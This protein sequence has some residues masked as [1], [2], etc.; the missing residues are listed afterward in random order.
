MGRTLLHF[1]RLIAVSILGL[2]LLIFGIVWLIEGISDHKPL[3][4]L[5]G[6]LALAIVVSAFFYSLSR[7]RQQAA[8]ENTTSGELLRKG[9]RKCWRCNTEFEIASA[10]KSP[11]PWYVT[12]IGVILSLVPISSGALGFWAF[13]LASFNAVKS[14][15]CLV[16]GI[17]FLLYVMKSAGDRRVRCPACGRWCGTTRPTPS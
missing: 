17:A 1:A 4:I 3:P 10:P 9:I 7:S 12:A 16:F 8:T 14:G 2:A 15:F 13:G 5:A 6:S 11:I